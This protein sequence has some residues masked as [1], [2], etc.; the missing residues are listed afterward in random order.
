MK[1]NEKIKDKDLTKIAGVVLDKVH[2]LD[3][4]FDFPL[5]TSNISYTNLNV[6][7]NPYFNGF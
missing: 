3:D 6:C 5:I 1:F 7:F 2:N 4:D